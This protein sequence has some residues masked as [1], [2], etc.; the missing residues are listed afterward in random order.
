MTTPETPSR[1]IS[2]KERLKLLWQEYGALALI[3]FAVLWVGTLSAIY[4]AVSMGWRQAAAVVDTTPAAE[5]PA[6]VARTDAQKTGEGAAGAGEAPA[7]APAGGAG[8]TAGT[9][10]I[11]YVIFRFTL[12]PRIAA[13]FVLTP[14]VA[15]ILERFGWRKPALKAP[16][17]ETGSS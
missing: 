7:S 12:A 2:P 15:R 9:F 5:A 8:K 1:K 16:A 14:L 10:G 11:A 4:V 17:G 3:V 6:E 13:T